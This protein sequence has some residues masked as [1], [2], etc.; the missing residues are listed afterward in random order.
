MRIRPSK[1]L[2]V[3]GLQCPKRLY[4]KIHARGRYP[5]GDLVDSAYFNEM[6]FMP[7]CPRNG[8]DTDDP[9]PCRAP[10][11]VEKGGV[12]H[13]TRHDFRSCRLCLCGAP[14]TYEESPSPKAFTGIVHSPN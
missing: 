13:S 6:G 12:V 11:H 4:L 2:Y 9:M 14:K 7:G 10:D 3:S 8:K 5:G 1:S